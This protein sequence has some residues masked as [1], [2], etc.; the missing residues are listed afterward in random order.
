MLPYHKY[1]HILISLWIPPSSPSNLHSEYRIKNGKINPEFFKKLK[2]GYTT[3]PRNGFWFACGPSWYN[4]EIEANEETPSVGTEVYRIIIKE[5]RL[6]K[7]NTLSRI[8][9]FMSEYG[10]EKKKGKENKNEILL[11][12][13]K[14]VSQ[15]YGGFIACPYIKNHIIAKYKNN[16]NKFIWYLLLDCASGCI[17]NLDAIGECQR[18]G[19]FTDKDNT[20]KELSKMLDKYQ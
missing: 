5:D 6:I 3:K 10:R 1:K 20:D 16:I 4:W 14:K 18:I 11:I 2:L 13:W 19:I 9:K 8:E 17:W 12:D 15:K 7:L